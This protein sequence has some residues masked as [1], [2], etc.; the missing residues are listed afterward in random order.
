M[1]LKDRTPLSSK[2]KHRKY[3]DTRDPNIDRVFTF[4][5]IKVPFRS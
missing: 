1:L 2:M 5:L 3:R 4:Y